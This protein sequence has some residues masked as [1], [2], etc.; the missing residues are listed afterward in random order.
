[1]RSVLGVHWED[2][3]WSWNSNTLAIWCEELT[4]WRDPVLWGIGG[5]RRM[6]QQRLRWLDGISDSLEMSLGKLWEFMMDREAWSAAVHGVIKSWAW[7]S[8]WTELN[9]VF[10]V[11]VVVGVEKMFLWAL[12]MLE[13]GVS[14]TSSTQL[15]TCHISLAI[16][17]LHIQ[18]SW[19]MWEFLRYFPKPF[20]PHTHCAFSLSNFIC[21]L[22]HQVVVI[23]KIPD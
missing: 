20:P 13:A 15:F 18:F 7:L 9:W 12:Y 14:L 17:L 5:R 16:S 8:V 2:W 3:C 6:G 23:C 11:V 1:M 10:F 22:C 21:F 19:L 4:H